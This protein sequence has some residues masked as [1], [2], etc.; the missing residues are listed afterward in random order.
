MFNVDDEVF[1]NPVCFPIFR[2][3]WGRLVT[4]P[5]IRPFTQKYV[6]MHLTAGVKGM[7]LLFPMVGFWYFGVNKRKWW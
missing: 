7:Y 1:P 5:K 3:F 4:L 6:A 2:V